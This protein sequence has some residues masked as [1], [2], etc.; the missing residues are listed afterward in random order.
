MLGRVVAT[1]SFLV[2]AIRIERY[3]PTSTAFCAFSGIHFDPA[4]VREPG[5]ERACA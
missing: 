5:G 2:V 3:D 1:G 4:N